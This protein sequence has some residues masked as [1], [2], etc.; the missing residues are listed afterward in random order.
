MT[1][2]ALQQAILAA[3][4]DGDAEG[5]FQTGLDG[6]I[7]IRVHE[8]SGPLYTVYRPALCL[9]AQGAKQV[10]AGDLQFHFGAMQSLAVG[11]DMPT[12]GRVTKA[13]REE[14]FL[15]L[16]FDLDLAILQEV[17]VQTP[18]PSSRGAAPSRGSE[19]GLFIDEV[20]S[21][22]CDCAVR[23][24]RLAEMPEAVPA[25]RPALMREI[26]YWLLAGRH[27][28]AIRRMALP[29][30][31]SQRILRAIEAM[32]G[33]LSRPLRVAEL[34][35]HAAMSPSAFHQ[36]F[37]DITAMSPLQYHKHLRL[38]EARR[39]MLAEGTAAAEAG[40]RVGYES[41]SQFS[42][43]YARLFGLPPRRDMMQLRAAA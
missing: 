42:R 33:E 37:R 18:P 39:L 28:G 12:I 8:P 11:V 16:A 7:V 14:P 5:E 38:L 17:A 4:P 31:H 35:E 32:K 2:T 41:A 19:T 1:A 13:S 22:L 10:L 20:D 27:G 9:V 3:L 30:S 26:S 43:D 36:H 25:L 34:A 40:F 24:L 21:A 23:L 6:L 15:A 29:G